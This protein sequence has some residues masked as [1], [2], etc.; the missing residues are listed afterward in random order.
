MKRLLSSMFVLGVAGT[1]LIP[2]AASAQEGSR[3]DASLLFTESIPGRS[4]GVEL[5]IDYVNPDDP[6]AK[7]PAVRRVVVEL[8]HG[9]RYDTSVPELCPASDAELMSVGPAACPPGSVVGRGVITLDTGIPG[10]GRIIASDTTFFNDTGELIF[11]NR[12]RQSGGHVV[13][14]GH[15]GERTIVSEAPFLPGTPPDGAAIDTVEIT[16]FPISSAVGNYITTPPRCPK[17]RH[18]VN[19]LTFTYDDGV[20]QLV[21]TDSPCV[22]PKKAKHK[23]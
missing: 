22:K 1:F 13:V 20:T 10:P 14:R 23:K 16:E 11:L 3:Q 17:S 18:W 6:A 7:P 4:T 12:E 21:T 2:A 19:R 8:A 5:R 15:V 9:A